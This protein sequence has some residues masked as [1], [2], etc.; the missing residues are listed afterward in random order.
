MVSGRSPLPG[1]EVRWSGWDLG[2]AE[3]SRQWRGFAWAARASVRACF[4]LSRL[5]LR[6][7]GA[8]TGWTKQ[9]R[10]MEELF[11]AHREKSGVA[12]GSAAQL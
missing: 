9:R 2:R 10:R 3:V 11:R 5:L 4:K 6:S 12:A 8:I 7:G 1:L